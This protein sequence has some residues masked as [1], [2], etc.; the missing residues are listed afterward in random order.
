MD[1]NLFY[2]LSTYNKFQ[3]MHLMYFVKIILGDHTNRN[4]L[5]ATS[6]GR[7]IVV[8]FRCIKKKKPLIVI[9]LWGTFTHSFDFYLISPQTF[10]FD[11]GNLISWNCIS[12]KIIQKW[13]QSNNGYLT[14]NINVIERHLCLKMNNN[15][16]MWQFFKFLYLTTTSSA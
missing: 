6:A 12:Y 16:N 2:V 10:L 8:C 5:T 1:N 4:I 15:Q 3:E 13:R 11:G 7:L 14:S 9:K